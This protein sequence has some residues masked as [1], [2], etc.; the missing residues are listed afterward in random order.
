M[1]SSVPAPIAPA[2]YLNKMNHNKTAF[3]WWEG[4]RVRYNFGLIKAGLGAFLCYI[5]VFQIF[6][7]K[8]DPDAEITVFTIILQ[9]IAYLIAM[10]LANL[11]YFFG[12]LSE[13]IIRPKNT[14]R[15]RN[16][17]YNIGYWFSVLLPFSVTAIVLVMGVVK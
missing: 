14:N 11:C 17:V 8:M 9:G 16:N 10:G 2:L 15:Y 7:H 12:V 5:I 3:Q 4:R 1:G 6:K 13:K